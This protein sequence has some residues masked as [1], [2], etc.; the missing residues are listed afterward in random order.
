MNCLRAELIT[1]L[2]VCLALALNAIT[3]SSS[4]SSDSASSFQS[5]SAMSKVINP[6]S[7]VDAFGVFAGTQM[8][9]E[10]EYYFERNSTSCRGS[11]VERC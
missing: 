8:L 10:L 2:M 3:S 5:C 4:L 9:E 1:F 6:S 7:D 11:F